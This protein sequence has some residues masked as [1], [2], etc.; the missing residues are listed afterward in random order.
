VQKK[1][2]AAATNQR[3][4]SRSKILAM[5]GQKSMEPSVT[6]V[7]ASELRGIKEKLKSEEDLQRERAAAA[8]DARQRQSL[9]EERKV[10]MRCSRRVCVR[11]PR[12]GVASLATLAAAALR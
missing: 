12:R 4:L 2:A 6:V 11:C 7:R 3:P 8:E 9:A 5:T 1:G 10:G